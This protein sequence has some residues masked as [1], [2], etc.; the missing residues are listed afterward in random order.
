MGS[1]Y[2]IT[3]LDGTLCDCRHR[4]DYA[5]IGQWDEFHSRCEADKPFQDVMFFLRHIRSDLG[6]GVLALTG[7][8]QRYSLTTHRWLV[9]HQAP[10]DMLLMRPDDNFEHDY[11]MKIK[12]LEQFFG[13]KEQVLKSVVLCLDDRDKVVEEF[14]NYGL[15]CWQVRQGDY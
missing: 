15:S 12:I 9:A 5:K 7:R 3:D 4:V 1:K 6:V 14:R 2:V 10:V 11:V 8:N 13:S